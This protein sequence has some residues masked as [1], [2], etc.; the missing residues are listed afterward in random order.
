MAYDLDANMESENTGGTTNI[1]KFKLEIVG[2]DLSV[3]DNDKEIIEISIREINDKFKFET[4]QYLNKK[5]D[6]TYK[7]LLWAGFDGSDGRVAPSLLWE[8]KEAIKTKLG[9]EK[10]EERKTKTGGINKKF[11]VKAQFEFEVKIIE[12]KTK[13]IYMLYTEAQKIKDEEYKSSKSAKS[14]DNTKMVEEA[15]DANDLP[16]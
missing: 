11:F 9:D 8:I 14:S 7:N 1:E 4:R 13:T 6:G 12:L 16:F 5:A 10:Y 15:I 2:Y 3:D